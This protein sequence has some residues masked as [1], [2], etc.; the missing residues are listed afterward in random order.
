MSSRPPLQRP[1]LLCP[2]ET[3]TRS[4]P[5]ARS[6][7]GYGSAAPICS[8]TCNLQP[9]PP[10]KERKRKE[11]EKEKGK[12]ER[13]IRGKEKKRKKEKRKRKKEKGKEK[14]KRVKGKEREKGKEKENRKKD[15]SFGYRSLISRD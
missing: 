14:V 12:K 15:A 8:P 4:L 6:L 13:K 2:T 7:K 11:K 1:P 9:F 5:R 10:F 3:S